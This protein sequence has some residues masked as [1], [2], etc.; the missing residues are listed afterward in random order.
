MII[1]LSRRLA[2]YAYLCKP[3]H[4]NNNNNHLPVASDTKSSIDR[5]QRLMRFSVMD[6]TLKH[7]RL[8]ILK[9]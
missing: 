5:A 4:N 8:D 2:Q 3:L 7:V 1:L 6:S 9:L